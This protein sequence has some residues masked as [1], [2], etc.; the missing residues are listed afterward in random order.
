MHVNHII[1]QYT[2]NSHGIECQLYLNKTGEKQ[3]SW[4]K[5]DI[6]ERVCLTQ[7]YLHLFSKHCAS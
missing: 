7:R 2:L 1:M 6:M 4:W 3:Y 5:L